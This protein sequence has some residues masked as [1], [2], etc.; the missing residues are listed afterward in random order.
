[1]RLPIR[2]SA[3]YNRASMAKH[4]LLTT[5]AVLIAVAALLGAG[6]S[7][8]VN[9]ALNAPSYIPPAYLENVSTS[10]V[11]D[12]DFE[13]FWQVW[14]L[15]DENYLKRDEITNEAK[16]YGA[17]SGL[18]G[19]LDDPYSEFFPPEESKKFQE[20]IKGNFGGIG[21]Q[22]GIRN[23]ALVVIAPLKESPAAKLGLKPGDKI[24]FVGET[25]TEGLGIDRAVQ[26]I[27]GP[28]D[29]KVKLTILREGWAEPKEYEIIRAEIVAPT[30][31]FTMKEGGVGYLQLY[32]FNGNTEKLFRSAVIGGL[33]HGM[34]GMVLDLRDNPGGYLD[35]AVHLAGWFVSR[36]EKVVSEESLTGIEQVFRASG[37]EALR[38]MPLTILINGGSASASE[39]LA[40]ALRDLRGVKLVGETTFGKGT[41]Q[42][43]EELEDGSSLKITIA[44]WVL[45]SGKILEGEGLVPDYE[46]KA[47]ENE[48]AEKTDPQ[49]EKAIE[50]LREEI[51]KK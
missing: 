12:T 29:S 49:L 23:D 43:L 7:L 36:G 41:V 39:I 1:M 45:P 46:V 19:A 21:A 50:L 8:G 27:R 47:P 18:V 5:F 25:S 14:N 9:I 11:P 32:S 40:G 44:H 42:Q 4:P 15:I 48:D 35:V 31:D 22:I 24:L 38:R 30:I 16:V 51:N 33:E 3:G 28:I 2:F 26:L 17:I 10:T 13:N 34:R 6:F 37:N 20:D